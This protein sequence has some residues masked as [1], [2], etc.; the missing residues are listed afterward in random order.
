MKSSDGLEHGQECHGL[1][2]FSFRSKESHRMASV[3]SG[4]VPTYLC[5]NRKFDPTYVL[6]VPTSASSLRTRC[7]ISVTSKCLSMTA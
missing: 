2:R 3:G 5:D 6:S 7:Y 4:R 1:L